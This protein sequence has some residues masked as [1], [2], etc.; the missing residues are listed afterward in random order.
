MEATNSSGNAL[1]YYVKGD[2]GKMP[3]GIRLH[4]SGMLSGRVAF[5]FFSLDKYETTIDKHKSTTF[6]KVYEFTVVAQ[7]QNRSAAGRFY[8][9]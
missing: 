5:D 6:D 3:Q 1:E 7:T 4:K 8:D 9:C 2:G